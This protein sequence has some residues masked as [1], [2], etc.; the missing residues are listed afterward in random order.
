[1]CAALELE[2]ESCY[3]DTDPSAAALTL[4]YDEAFHHV[5]TGC[6]PCDF[7]RVRDLTV[8]QTRRNHGLTGW[9]C[10]CVLMRV[11]LV[12]ALRLAAL[13]IH[14]DN[15]DT[16]TEK[17]K[18][19]VRCVQSCVRLV[20]RLC[21]CLCVRVCAIPHPPQIAVWCLYPRVF[22]S[23]MLARH[24]RTNRN[25][26]DDRVD[27]V[28]RLLPRRRPKTVHSVRKDAQSVVRFRVFPFPVQVVRRHDAICSRGHWVL[29]FVLVCR[30][31]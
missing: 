21:L 30:E 1:M 28:A 19:F 23:P 15:G 27:H 12:Q 13:A 11:W 7:D 25:V 14:R 18:G 29:W 16:A 10:V 6:Y 26:T 24:A 31:R 22:A 17:G 4:A 5:M 8:C 20:V 3:K 2:E 9:L